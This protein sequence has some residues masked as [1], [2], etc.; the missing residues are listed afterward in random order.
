MTKRVSEE[1]KANIRVLYAGGMS[2]GGIAKLCKMARKTV[3]RIVAN[4]PDPHNGRAQRV[5]AH[6][7]ATKHSYGTSVLRRVEAGNSGLLPTDFDD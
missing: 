5:F 2:C 7:H 4:I 6:L 1:K 3:K